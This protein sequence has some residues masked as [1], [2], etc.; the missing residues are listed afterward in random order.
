M[1]EL[2]SESDLLDGEHWSDEE[3]NLKISRPEI[4]A[5]DAG[6]SSAVSIPKQSSRNFEKADFSGV[7]KYITNV[8]DN[9][10]NEYPDYTDKD[11]RAMATR[12]WREMTESERKGTLRLVLAYCEYSFIRLAI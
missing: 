2:S 12:R 5:K 9:L 11:L 6:K 7:R 8:L 4:K 1:I 10:R 3:E